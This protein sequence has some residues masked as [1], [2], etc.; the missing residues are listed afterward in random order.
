MTKRDDL[1]TQSLSK[2]LQDVKIVRSEMQQGFAEVLG[3]FVALNEKLDSHT[4]RFDSI[5]TRFDSIDALVHQEFASVRQEQQKLTPEI[6]MR[7]AAT[8]R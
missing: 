4:A 8:L 7:L 1:P 3:Q 6:K 2:M 5:D